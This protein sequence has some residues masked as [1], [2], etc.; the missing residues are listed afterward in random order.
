[1][2]VLITG[3]LRAAS[4]SAGLALLG[5]GCASAAPPGAA[6]A[7]SSAVTSASP[8]TDLCRAVSAA[9]VTAAVGHPVGPGKPAQDPYVGCAW[10]AQRSNSQ[11][12]VNVLYIGQDAFQ[13]AKDSVGQKVETLQVLKGIG[14]EAYAQSYAPIGPPLLLMRVSDTYV[15]VSVAIRDGNGTDVAQAVDLAAEQKLAT[16]IVPAL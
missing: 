11:T 8:R 1:M 6:G 10:T 2:R 7:A 5:G 14:D 12:A 3:A 4:M 16:F 15:S 13:A 9:Q